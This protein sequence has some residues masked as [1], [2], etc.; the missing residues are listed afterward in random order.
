MLTVL[1]IPLK[2][3]FLTGIGSRYDK[4]NK[5]NEPQPFTNL[6][7][8]SDCLFDFLGKESC[9]KVTDTFAGT[10]ILFNTSK[11]QDVGLMLCTRDFD[12]NGR[13]NTNFVNETIDTL[14]K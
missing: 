2:N 7:F 4:T 1:K 11:K 14:S 3:R 6:S 12:A 8:T 9:H 10:G 13:R 5:K